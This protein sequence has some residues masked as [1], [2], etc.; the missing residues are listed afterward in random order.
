MRAKAEGVANFSCFCNH[1]TIVPP[2]RALLESPDLRLDGFIGPGHVSTVVGARPFEFIPADY[3]KPI[4]IS[5]FE[6]LDLL[7][8]VHMI[9]RQLARG[10]LRGREP[11]HARRAVRRA[12]RRRCRCSPRCSS[13]GRT[14]SGAGSAS[15][16]IA[17]CKLSEAYADLDAE[18]R[19]SVPGV[20]VADPKAC[21]CGEV[22]KGVIRPW[23]CKVFG[24]ACTPERP[25]GTC[26]VSSEGA[27]AAYYNFG[28]FAR[29]RAVVVTRRAEAA[30]ARDDRDASR[31][32]PPALPRRA[33]HDGPRRRR[34]GDAGAR[35]RGCWP[36]PSGIDE[37]ADAGG[38]ST[39]LALTTDSFVVKPI[40]F[41]GGS[42]GELAVNGTVND[43]AVG[44]RPAARADPL[45]RARG[46]PRG[47]RAARRGRGD[48]ARRRARRASRS[49]AATRRSSSAA[50]ATRCTSAR[51]GSAGVDRR[52]RALARRRSGRATGS[53][54]RARSAS[55][56]PRSC[57][58]AASSSS[59]PRSSPTRGRCGR[60]STRC[61]TPPGP[62][63]RCMRDA[64]RGGVASVLNE[65]AR[66]SGVAV[67]R[68]RGGRAGAARR[69]PAR[70]RSSGID[71]MYVANEGVLVAFV[72]PR[73]APRHALAALRA[74]PGCERGGRDRRGQ[75]RPRGHGARGDGVRRHAGSWTC[76]WATRSRGSAERKGALMAASRVRPQPGRDRGG[77]GPRHLDDHGPLLR[78]RLR[79]D[80][81]GDEP[82]PRG[83]RHAGSSPACPGWS[84]TTRCSPT[85]TA[86][87]SWRPGGRP[88]RGELDPFVLVVEGSIAERADQRRRPLGGDRH[89]PGDRPAD[90]DQRVG[91]PAR[92]EGRGGR[93]DRH[94]RHLRRHPGDEEQPDRRDGAAPTTSAG[95]GSRRPAC[96]SS[97]SPAA[98]RSPTT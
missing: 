52:A 28:R 31:S 11:V 86:R 43:L 79:R 41:P 29:E 34:Q 68:A 58:P 75:D 8:S 49:S 10:P 98:R 48:R 60:P 53:S 32:K 5:G 23:E 12:T 36:R 88:R 72:A 38:A 13:C 4:V 19:F 21:Q 6:P 55:T 59:T 64:T 37:L 2:L 27:C 62:A 77:D 65:L 3:G 45:A 15:S 89:R 40:R 92:A 81:L 97:T 14:S 44:R 46:G 9:L 26:M 39:A 85:R 20:R 91:R 42:I 30:R 47:R 71:P 61:S 24:T 35:S 74:V 22:L 76:S 7:Q 87:T 25:I 56:A 17:A 80:D 90:H 70:A 69:S 83:H 84:C 33:H 96:R 51:P 82:E 66:A 73:G 18:L 50:A 95:T 1:V 67:R 93:R 16:R 78:R 63:L 57:S 94:L 54:S